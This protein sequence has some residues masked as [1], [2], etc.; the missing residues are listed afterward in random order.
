MS[1]SDVIARAITSQSS[2]IR[3]T[4]IKAKS[5]HAAMTL[6]AGVLVERGLRF[7]RYVILTRILVPDQFGLM[8]LVMVASSAFEALTEVGVKQSVIQNKRGADTEYLNVA[9]WFQAVRGLGLF[10]IGYLAAP[11]IS[12]FY[13]KPELLWLLRVAFLAVLFRGFISPRAYVLEKQYRFGMVVFLIQGSGIL[14]AV[15]AIVLAFIIRN[16]WALVIGFV[17]EFAIMCVLSYVFVPFLPRFRMERRCLGELMD[18]ARGMLGVAILTMIAF[19]IDVLV[20]GKVVSGDEL[21]MYYLAMTVVLLPITLFGRVISPVLLPAFSEKQD[22]REALLRVI[23]RVTRTT[24]VFT[25]PLVAFMASSAGGVLAVVYGSEYAAV[26]VPFAVLCLL[27]VFRTQTPVLSLAY[28]AVGQPR[29]NRRFVVVRAAVVGGLIYP[30]IV[31]FGLLGAAAVVVLGNGIGLLTQ[32]FWSRR[33]VD[34]GFRTY[35]CCYL[36]GLALALPIVAMNL[37]R[38]SA[39]E[40]PLVTLGLSTVVFCGSLVAGGLLFVR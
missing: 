8:A 14:G 21:G 3:G 16:V 6:A 12:S 24:A 30:A 31:H 40:S 20:L 26:T 28:L 18:F 4:S 2:R 34:L 38:L 39:L 11:W 9:W 13:E 36:P 17:S 10:S 35:A 27:I 25:L 32:V 33:I 37:L 29:L 22:D 19:E 15:I 23:L 1:V 7:V 5:T